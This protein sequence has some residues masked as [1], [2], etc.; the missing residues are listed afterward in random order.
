M[1]DLNKELDLNV[2]AAPSLTLDA[3]PAPSLTL[4]PL[5]EEKAVEETKKAE[6]VQVED[7]P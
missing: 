3:A 6:P 4:D 7:T 1:A 5:A 2:S